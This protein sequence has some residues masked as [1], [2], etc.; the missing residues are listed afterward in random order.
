[1]KMYNI[2]VPEQHVDDVAEWCRATLP[3]DTYHTTWRLRPDDV[4]FRFR[5]PEHMALFE[6]RWAH[7][8]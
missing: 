5:E 3:A 2:V 1:M 4:I 6:L 7:L 8:L